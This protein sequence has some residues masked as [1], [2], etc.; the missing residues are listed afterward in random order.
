MSTAPGADVPL[1]EDAPKPPGAGEGSS[2]PRGLSVFRFILFSSLMLGAGYAGL[3]LWAGSPPPP[4]YIPVGETPA[5]AWEPSPAYL[6]VY[7]MLKLRLGAR[8]TPEG[9]VYNGQLGYAL[10]GAGAMTLGILLGGVLGWIAGERVR[11]E[12]LRRRAVYVAKVQAER[13][14]RG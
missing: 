12:I 3:S 1:D 4:G 2:L 8:H 7:A 14:R 9:Y 10:F 6:P 5:S 11:Q 13:E